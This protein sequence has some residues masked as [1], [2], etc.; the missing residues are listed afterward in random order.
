[1]DMQTALS[2]LDE[3]L[4]RGLEVI[5]A[6][7]GLN[8]I[9]QA[10]V[11]IFGR[12]SRFT[13]VQKSL[14]GLP[15]EDRKAV[16][17]RANEVRGALG[18]ALEAARTNLTMAAERTRLEADAID[19]SLPG[20]RPPMGSLNPL[21]ITEMDIV[22]AFVA[23]GFTVG[24]GPEIETDWY[25]FTALNIPPD[26]PARS[27]KDSIFVDVEGHPDLLLRTETSAV[28]IHTME[29]QEPPIAI[30]AP[31]RVYRREAADATHSSVFHQVEGL[32]VDEGVTFADLKGTLEAFARAI[33]GPEQQIRLVP[34]YF[35]FV[36]PGAE[37]YVSCFKCGGAGCRICDRGWIEMMGAG[38]VH[39]AVLENVGY[40]SE[41]FT[42]FAFGMGLER[43]T[44]VRYGVPDIRLFADGDVRFLEQFTG[45][46]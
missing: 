2:T 34:S 33:F 23:L 44:M 19:I 40:D 35:P 26:H 13:L 24:E 3:E 4:D 7:R 22:D 9:A 43:V 41:R 8:D 42:G 28:Q 11:V 1:M 32:V 31:G 27:M 15:P 45:A 18:T 12:K 20:R 30:I 21:T 10:D 29:T 16:G 36:E 37:V 5:A 38:M 17:R 39:P 6:A 25:N 46:R 14:G